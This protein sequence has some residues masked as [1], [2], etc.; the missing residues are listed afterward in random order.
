MSSSSANSFSDFFKILVYSC[1]WWGHNFGLF[2]RLM[3]IDP[4]ADTKSSININFISLSLDIE[5]ESEGI[6]LFQE[7]YFAF[8]DKLITRLMGSNK[9]T[10]H[11]VVIDEGHIYKLFIEHISSVLKTLYMSY[12]PL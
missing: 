9:V 5:D 1:F 10:L 6:I 7:F 3:M 2:L 11:T 12:T 4:L 8:L